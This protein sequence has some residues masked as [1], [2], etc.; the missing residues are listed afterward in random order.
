MRAQVSVT[1]V[2]IVG[3]ALFGNHAFA[4]FAIP[5]DVPVDR[6]VKNLKSYIA[7][8]PDDAQG[9]Y[10]LARVHSLAFTLK[11][12]SIGAY[13]GRA[14]P[15]PA[16]EDMQRYRRQPVP[17]TTD[18]K[19]APDK[20]EELTSSELQRHVREAVTNYNKAIELDMKQGLFFLSFGSFLESASAQSSDCSLA[21]LNI[22][23]AIDAKAKDAAVR[24]VQDIVNG[25]SDSQEAERIIAT[26]NWDWSAHEYPSVIAALHD[27][28]L[29][30]D[31]P[32][33]PEIRRL[34]DLHWKQATKDCYYLAFKLS[35]PTE[36]Q[37]KTLPIKGLKALVS[38][39][40]AQSFLR[41]TKDSENQQFERGR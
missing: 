4:K 33:R 26:S 35:F 28:Q 22:P 23:I 32:H 13:E 7:E 21:P 5:T 16:D 15:S 40:A 41:V 12:R 31:W 2:V 38:H 11:A 17:P 27:A 20:Q 34:L 14:L 8:H 37:N 3:V 6:L 25:K 9:Y 1:A 19:Q 18:G 39:E 30:Q 10:N 29:S 24:M 36:L